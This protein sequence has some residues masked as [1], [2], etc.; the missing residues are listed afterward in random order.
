MDGKKNLAFE[1][2]LIIK[3]IVTFK[4]YIYCSLKSPNMEGKAPA[5]PWGYK[6][7]LSL[8]RWRR[9]IDGKVMW[10]FA[11]IEGQVQSGRVQTEQN[12]STAWKW[13]GPPK[14]SH[15]GLDAWRSTTKSRSGIRKG[16]LSRDKPVQK[17]QAE[18]NMFKAIFKIWICMDRRE[19][20]G[21]IKS[22]E[23]YITLKGFNLTL[24]YWKLTIGLPIFQFIS[25]GFQ[26][27]Y[28]SKLDYT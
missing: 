9:E 20:L 13:E 7:E 3:H 5:K 6:E 11:V 15:V 23:L 10:L 24:E 2:Y 25:I 22:K 4:C 28:H 1:S 19:R 14:G 17:H 16:P 18:K 8:P 27:F 12:C 21:C 26:K